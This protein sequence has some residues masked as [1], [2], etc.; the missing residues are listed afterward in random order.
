MSRLNLPKTNVESVS[1]KP[2]KKLTYE[3]LNPSLC[4]TAVTCYF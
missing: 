4:Q 2:A 3:T 1:I